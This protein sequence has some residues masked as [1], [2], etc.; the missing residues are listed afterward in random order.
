[1]ENKYDGAASTVRAGE[2]KA[3]ITVRVVQVRPNGDLMIEGSRTVQVNNEKEE[4]GLSGVVRPKDVS[5]SNT[6]YS[7]LIADAKITYKG[8]GAVNT[9]ARPGFLTRIFN[10]IF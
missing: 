4:I 6:V 1:L 2:L 9:G 5:A 7:Y 3:R 10:W 8:K